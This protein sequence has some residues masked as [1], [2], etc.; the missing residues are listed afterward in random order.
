MPPLFTPGNFANNN[1]NV[2]GNLV[3]LNLLGVPAGFDVNKAP[4]NTLIGGAALWTMSGKNSADYA[5]VARFLEFLASPV[6]A[7]E[8]SEKTGYVPV[9]RG[10]YLALKNTGHFKENPELA[11]FLIKLSAL[12][13]TLKERST[14]ILD[15]R[16]PP[17]DLLS[18]PSEKR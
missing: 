9:T 7:A 8:W 1:E 17:F 12:E 18:K 13:Q 15:E 4:Y 6:V 11:I 5:G 16:T 10:S 2:F 14:L 3:S